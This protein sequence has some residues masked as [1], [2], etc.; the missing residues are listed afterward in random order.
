MKKIIT[1]ITFGIFIIPSLSF[2]SIDNNLK[3][4]NK[5]PQVIELQEFLIDKGFLQGSATG[6]FYSL[7]LKAVKSFQSA[8]SI[9]TTGYV[10]I[11]TR[12]AINTDL[13]SE[14]SSSTA[15]QLAET[16]TTTASTSTSPVITQLQLQNQFL[17]QQL[18]QLQTQVQ[19]QQQQNQTIQQIQQDTRRIAQNTTPVPTPTPTPTSTPTSTPVIVGSLAINKADDSPSGNIN[20]SATSSDMVM[21]GK[22]TLRAKDESIKLTQLKLSFQTNNPSIDS[23]TNVML[24][25]NGS[26][27]GATLSIKNGQISTFNLGSSLITSIVGADLRN[28]NILE[29]YSAPFTDNNFTNNDTIQ[30]VIEPNTLSATGLNSFVQTNVPTEP[31]YGNV[32]TITK[33]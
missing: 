19:I 20:R 18:S 15:E 5:G 17:Q 8:N 3:Y 9:P 29:I 28:T 26:Q 22:F 23:L 21:L 33:Q 27:I 13:A 24:F 14:T 12:T 7:T 6:N 30:V 10:G 4:G 31:I 1:I 2:A 11:L 16:G 25:L 32:L